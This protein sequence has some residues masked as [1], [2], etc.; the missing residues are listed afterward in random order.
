MPVNLDMSGELPA[1]DPHEV[2]ELPGPGKGISL[3]LPMSNVLPKAIIQPNYKRP[4]PVK[5]DRAQ[6]GLL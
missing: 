3:N 2:R 4:G 5:P 6:E 1:L